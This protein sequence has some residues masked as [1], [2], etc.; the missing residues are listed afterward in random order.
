MELELIDPV[1]FLGRDHGAASRFADAI[2][3]LARRNNP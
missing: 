1:L 2:E 3:M